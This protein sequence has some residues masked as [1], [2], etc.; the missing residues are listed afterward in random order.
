MSYTGPPSVETLSC[1]QCKTSLTDG[2]TTF[3]VKSAPSANW[4]EVVGLWQCHDET[5]DQYFDPV[6][7]QLRVPSNTL[8]FNLNLIEAHQATDF[9][10]C[11]PF[12]KTKQGKHLTC[13]FCQ[14]V[15]GFVAPTNP[16]TLSAASLVSTQRIEQEQRVSQDN[17]TYSFFAERLDQ[18]SDAGFQN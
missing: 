12:V 8:L 7:R 11:F 14:N 13:Q 3:N 16:V 5:F 17:F 1:K 6:T 9:A 4:R 2:S 15:V 10:T 18:F